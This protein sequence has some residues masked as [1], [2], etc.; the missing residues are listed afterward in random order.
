LKTLF[1]RYRAYYYY[2]VNRS[3]VI[4]GQTGQGESPDQSKGVDPQKELNVL[5][6]F[7]K[8][9]RDTKE[10]LASV[11]EVWDKKDAD[12]ILKVKISEVIRRVGNRKRKHHNMFINII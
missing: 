1:L 6:G 3:P 12:C 5:D 8:K 10:V 9:L 4:G 7:S 11:R 2:L